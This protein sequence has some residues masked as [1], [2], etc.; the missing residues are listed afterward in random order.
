METQDDRPGFSSMVL[1][2]DSNNR[3]VGREKDHLHARS[4]ALEMGFNVVEECQPSRR[5]WRHI[6]GC[7]QRVEV[8]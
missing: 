7:W 8:Q 3:V 1:I 6:K 2:I 5:Q 4:L